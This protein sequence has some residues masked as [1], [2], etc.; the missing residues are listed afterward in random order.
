MLL[1]L[2]LNSSF[3]VPSGAMRGHIRARGTALEVR[4]YAGQKRYLTKTVRWQGSKKATRKAAEAELTA[5][6]GELDTGAHTGPDASVDTLLDRWWRQKVSDWS[7]STAARY[8]SALNAHV[9]PWFGKTLVR[10]VRTEDIDGFLEQ[11]RVE[12]MGPASR[13]KVLGILR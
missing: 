2:L 3:V 10:K 11:L 12:G 1:G 13:A 4:V 9:R 8:E 7:P 6:L 5:M